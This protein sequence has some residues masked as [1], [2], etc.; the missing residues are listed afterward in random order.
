[1]G[2]GRQWPQVLCRPIMILFFICISFLLFP[3]RLTEANKAAA[4]WHSQLCGPDPS[5]VSTLVATI[6]WV[7]YYTGLDRTGVKNNF[8]M[9]FFFHTHT[10]S[11]MTACLI[12]SRRPKPKLFIIL[13]LPLPTTCLHRR[14]TVCFQ[15]LHFRPRFCQMI[16]SPALLHENG[17]C[18]V[19]LCFNIKYYPAGRDGGV[20]LQGVH[21]NTQQLFHLSL[22]QH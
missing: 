10:P 7:R 19:D 1:M 8:Y 6:L 9:L 20:D 22:F 21:V 12:F 11:T 14:V 15:H 2:E 17:F 4:P 3:S 18:S 5:I 16:V 13:G